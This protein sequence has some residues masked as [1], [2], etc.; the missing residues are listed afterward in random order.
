MFFSPLYYYRIVNKSEVYDGYLNSR[1]KVLI[2]IWEKGKA[3]AEYREVNSASFRELER[4]TGRQKE[5]LKSWHDLYQR[6]PNK[7]LFQ[8][9]YAEPKAKEWTK[10]AL[11]QK[12]TP[13]CQVL[14]STEKNP[15]ATGVPK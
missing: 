1:L 15:C 8:S 6:W 5:S 12:W 3:V 14:F 7:A 11:N 10:K 4:Q 9:E 2:G 13:F